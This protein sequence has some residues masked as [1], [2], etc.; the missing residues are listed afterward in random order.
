M[1][2]SLENVHLIKPDPDPAALLGVTFMNKNK[3]R[4]SKAASSAGTREKESK[5]LQRIQRESKEGEWPVRI[6]MAG[7][8]MNLGGQ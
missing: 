3:E 6:A 7:I 4:L 1:E 2:E 5:A 8:R